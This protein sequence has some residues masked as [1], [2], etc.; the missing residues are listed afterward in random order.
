[1]ILQ[2]TRLDG[3]MGG[4]SM[5]KFQCLVEPAGAG[6]SWMVRMMSFVFFVAD[7]ALYVTTYNNNTS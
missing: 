3:G 6:P 1:M 2:L 7:E 4:I 5:F